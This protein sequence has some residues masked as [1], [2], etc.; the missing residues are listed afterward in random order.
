MLELSSILF[1]GFIGYYW[2]NQVNALDACRLA[3]KQVTIQ[4]GWAF[5]DDSVMQKKISIQPRLGKLSLL[6]QFEFE[7]SDI[8]AKRFNGIITHH[9]G[10]VTEIKYFHANEIE[11]VALTNR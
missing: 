2:Y 7:F 8:D 1:L 11:T 4:K 5:L 3:G 10:V 6:R 9:G